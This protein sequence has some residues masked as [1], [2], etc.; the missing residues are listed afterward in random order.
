[1]SSEALFAV[2]GDQRIVA[3]NREATAVFGY[4]LDAALGAHCYQL[5]GCCDPAGGRFCRAG[6]AVISSAA[7]GTAPP[8]LRLNARTRDGERVPIE[9]STIILFSGDHLDTVMHLCRLSERVRPA[10]PPRALRR[11]LTRR[12]RQVLS[13]LCQRRSTDEIAADLGITA[14]T[15]R[16]HMQHLLEKLAVHSRAEAVA[17]AYD[18]GLFVL[19][20][21]RSN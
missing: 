7:E 17:L 16:N 20:G 11:T 1:M 2:D 9:V 4:E 13:C 8:T 10:R 6:C 14:V 12:E 19:P 5:L 18:D 15:V 3:W 21:P